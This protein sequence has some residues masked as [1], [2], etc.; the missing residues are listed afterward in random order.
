LRQRFDN[1]EDPNDQTAQ[2]Q[3]PFAQGGGFGNFFQQGGG[4]QFFQ[5]GHKFNVKFG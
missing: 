1:G 3:N 5:Q 4:Q 2:Q